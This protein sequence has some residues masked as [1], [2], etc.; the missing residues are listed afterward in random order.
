M[1]AFFLKVSAMAMGLLGLVWQSRS[2]AKHKERSKQAQKSLKK[3]KRAKKIRDD[4]K[5][6]STDNIRSGL[7]KHRR[8]R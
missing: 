5:R 8:K 6:K 2:A 3:A 1:K 4:I 7:R